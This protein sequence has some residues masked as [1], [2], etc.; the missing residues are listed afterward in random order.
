MSRATA[1]TRA[2]LDTDPLTDRIRRRDLR[3]FR[4]RFRR[5]H[6]EAEG[7]GVKARTLLMTTLAGVS[8]LMVVL[9]ASIMA[10]TLQEGAPDADAAGEA[11]WQALIAAVPVIMLVVFGS[12]VI[13]SRERRGGYRA[14]YRL[15]RF[16]EANGMTYL[17]GPMSDGHFGSAR[18]YFDLTRVMRP[19]AAS[20]VEFGNH[21]IVTARR[22]E[23]APRFG[24][25]AMVRLAQEMPHIRVVARRGLVRRAL[26]M[27]SRPERE[28]R[29]SLEG[30]FDRHFAL[31]CPAGSERDALYLFT[32]DVLAVLID[33]VRGLD[34]EV[35][36]DRLLLTSYDDVV[37]RDPE[38]WRDV[39]E[40]TT[41]LVAKVDRWE[42]WR[43]DPIE[44]PADPS[45]LDAALA[46]MGLP[47]AG[48]ASRQRPVRR[49]RMTPTLGGVIAVGLP[50]LLLVVG[51][52]AVL[53]SP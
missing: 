53:V 16:A 50:L 28:Q 10:E 1:L 18:R 33:R 24:G 12:W 51:W 49:L 14:H 44:R 40:A 47:D 21:E 41:A 36:G 8:A 38:R 48:R 29:L 4:R 25:Y 35:V 2:R 5:A 13:R 22:R 26:T 9:L 30:D 37:T 31:Y 42:R 27:M 39:I 32:P 6:P 20:G 23:G 43:A 17:P 46:A 34:V 19:A 15:L 52:I 45:A 7:S 11:S 3:A